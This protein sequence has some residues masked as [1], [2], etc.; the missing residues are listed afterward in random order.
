MLSKISMAALLAIS[1][2]L[3]HAYDYGVDTSFPIHHNFLGD[4]AS[5]SET[6]KTFGPQKVDL[7]HEYIK[8]CREKYTPL[9]KAHECTHNEADRLALNLRQPREM[10]NYTDVGFTKLRMPDDMWNLLREF[11]DDTMNHGGIENLE[12][13]HWPEANTYTNHW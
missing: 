4:G 2:I 6:L 9:N 13:E 10:T 5:V 1:P 8:G 3:S 7:Y 11:W 12:E